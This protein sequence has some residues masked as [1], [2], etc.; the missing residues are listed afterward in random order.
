M[1]RLDSF[2]RLV[3]EQQVSDLHFHAGNVPLVRYQ[4]E[5]VPLPFR[6]LTE[7]EAARFVYEVLTLAQ[8]HELD[9]RKELDFVYEL[10]GVGRSEER[11]VGKEC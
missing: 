2:L 6:V 10:A 3:S 7:R 5:L 8:R 9:E 11:R 1:A 4:G